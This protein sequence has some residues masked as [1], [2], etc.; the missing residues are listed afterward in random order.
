LKKLKLIFPKLKGWEGK[1]LKKTN[2]VHQDSENQKIDRLKTLSSFW[3]LFF[4]PKNKST[5]LQRQVI[6]ILKKSE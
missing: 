2:L 5:Y 1:Y 4:C 3:G 6:M